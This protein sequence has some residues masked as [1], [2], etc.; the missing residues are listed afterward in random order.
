[1][2]ILKIDKNVISHIN[3]HHKPIEYDREGGQFLKSIDMFNKIDIDKNTKSYGYIIR[4]ENRNGYNEKVKY[5]ILQN[6]VGRFGSNGIVYTRLDF[7]DYDE[8]EN[9]L[10]VYLYDDSDNDYE[11]FFDEGGYD[12]GAEIK[13]INCI[14]LYTTSLISLRLNYNIKYLY[15]SCDKSMKGLEPLIDIDNDNYNEELKKFHSSRFFYSDEED[16]HVSHHIILR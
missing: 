16:N 11:E 3:K 9:I 15:M 10:E 12:Y 8:T 13:C 6:Q 4:L 2:G 14:T 7:M 5:D 1:M